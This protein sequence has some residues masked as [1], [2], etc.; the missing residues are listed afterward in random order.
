MPFDRLQD[1]EAIANW[2]QT[3]SR[4]GARTPMP[5]RSDARPT[6]AFRPASLGFR[7]GQPSPPGRR[8][9]AVRPALDA[10]LHAVLPG[11]APAFIRLASRQDRCRPRPM[12]RCSS[13]TV[14]TNVSTLRCTFNLG[15]RPLGFRPAAAALIST[16]LIDGDNRAPTLRSSRSSHDHP[17]ASSCR[18]SVA[19]SATLG[20][21]RRR[22]LGLR[23]WPAS[24][25]AT[26]AC[27]SLP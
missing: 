15:G 21:P 14:R 25:D 24:S 20:T 12:T 4:D 16:G 10:A 18:R 8:P 2:P 17:R 7:R 3:L 19:D 1:P 5:W 26:P 9:A 11:P 6:S 13:S 22:A 23:A 27:G